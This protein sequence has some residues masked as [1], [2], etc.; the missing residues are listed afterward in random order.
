MNDEW[1]LL[2][3][4]HWRSLARPSVFAVTFF[5][6]R[7]R[8]MKDVRHC[9]RLNPLV[10]DPINRDPASLTNPPL[11]NRVYSGRTVMDEVVFCC[12]CCPCF[13]YKMP[14]LLT[15]RSV[16]ALAGLNGLNGRSGTWWQG[17]LMFHIYAS[18]DYVNMFREF[19][20]SADIGRILNW[21]QTKP[22][23]GK[24]RRKLIRKGEL[25]CEL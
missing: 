5:V 25:N 23:A 6:W 1:S 19:T 22:P 9:C 8:L 16:A 2:R 24:K 13:V 21:T 11:S 15:N 3:S 18:L 12:C 10:C 20:S 4:S 14:S 7:T 17:G